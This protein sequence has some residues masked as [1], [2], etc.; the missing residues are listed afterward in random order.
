MFLAMAE[1]RG[2]SPEKAG[3]L[4]FAVQAEARRLRA[5]SVSKAREAARAAGV[6]AARDAAVVAHDG[7]VS[8]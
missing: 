5:G 3:D 2:L 1:K 8:R 6:R 4:Y 7:A